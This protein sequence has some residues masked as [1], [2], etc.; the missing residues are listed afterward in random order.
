MFTRNVR[1][2]RLISQSIR[3]RSFSTTSI[4]FQPKPTEKEILDKTIPKEILPVENQLPTIPQLPN[5]LPEPTGVKS[6]L[7]DEFYLIYRFGFHRQLRY[8]QVLKL[9]QTLAT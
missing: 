3:Y 1:I 6:K 9:A 7:F 4:Y 2:I 5:F 8:V